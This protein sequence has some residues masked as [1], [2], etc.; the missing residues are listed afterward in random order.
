MQGHKHNKTTF[1]CVSKKYAGQGIDL[2][3]TCPE[4]EFENVQFIS[5]NEAI[6][7]LNGQAV[8]NLPPDPSRGGWVGQLHCP[9]SECWTHDHQRTLIS[10]V[11]RPDDLSKYVHAKR[12]TSQQQ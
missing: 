6:A 3:T 12:L 4:C 10:Y 2:H 11:L 1:T 5:W 9:R 7:L 8:P